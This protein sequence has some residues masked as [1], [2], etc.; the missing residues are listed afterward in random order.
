MAFLFFV[1]GLEIDRVAIR[2]RPVLPSLAGRVLGLGLALAL[3]V[4]LR[5][6]GLAQA[7][8]IVVLTQLA[9]AAGSMAPAEAAPLVGAGMVSVIVFPLLGLKLAGVARS[10]AAARDLRDGL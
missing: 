9:V 2:D 10:P 8:L 6:A 5:A 4:G 3:A 7:W 1:A